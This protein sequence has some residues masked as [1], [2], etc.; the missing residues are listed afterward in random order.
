MNSAW[1]GYLLMLQDLFK[2]STSFVS[3]SSKHSRKCFMK[4]M[5][6]ARKITGKTT[7]QYFGKQ[8]SISHLTLFLSNCCCR[9]MC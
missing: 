7:L 6:F 2:P 3:N 8:Q 4:L 9:E 1:Q 5:D